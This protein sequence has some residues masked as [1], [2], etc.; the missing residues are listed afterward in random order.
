MSMTISQEFAAFASGLRWGGLPEGVRR[1]ARLCLLD[2]LGATLAGSGTPTAELAAGL[3]ARYGAG[4][5]AQV[6][7]RAQRA[8]APFAALA[9]GIAG[10]ALELDDGHRYAIGLHNACTA[11]PAAL[12][13][14]EE[15]DDDLERLLAALVVGYEVAGRVGTALNP[16]H[17]RAGFHSTGTIGP[18][19]AAAAVAYLR[20]LPS[21]PFARALGI[22]GSAAGGI[23]EFLSDGSTSKHFH[24]GH[25]ALAGVLAVD[26]AAGGM[27]G[28]LSIFEGREGFYRVYGGVGDPRAMTDGLGA[29]YELEQVYFKLHAACGHNFGPIDATL[30]LRGRAGPEEVERV[31]VRTYRAA[32]ILDERRPR[33]KAA[34]KFS[35]PY[36]VAAAWVHGRA[37]EELFGERFLADP[38]LQG[39]AARVE[40]VEDPELEAEFPR[41]RA[42]RVEVELRDGR[43]LEAY[44]DVPRGMPER[45]ASEAELVA[46]FSG[47]A[48]P[49]IGGVATEALRGFVLDGGRAAVRRVMAQTAPKAG[50]QVKL[51]EG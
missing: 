16:A 10:H 22:A 1:R 49:V 3:A 35:I 33:T 27:T 9:N 47:L 2:M 5:G 40:M 43:R 25:A 32:A 42:A 14:A 51:L 26:L 8:N 39:L 6:I 7:G 19:G 45:P 24:G 36:C 28:P 12:A 21:E 37:T 46:K 50:D 17:R 34:A 20:D 30:E 48:E 15:Q 29:R 18:F 4:G 38:G 13:V 44:V 23:F 31:V 41:T 11:T